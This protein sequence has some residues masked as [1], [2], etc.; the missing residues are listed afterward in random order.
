MFRTPLPNE[1]ISRLE[2]FGPDQ[3]AGLFRAGVE[4]GLRVVDYGRL[5]DAWGTLFSGLYLSAEELTDEMQRGEHR[6]SGKNERM[7]REFINADCSNGGLFVVNVI[8]KG[9]KTDRAALIMIADLENLA[10]IEYRGTTAVHLLADA[11][12]KGVRPVFI[13]KA[14]K[15]LLSHVYDRRGIPVI[16]TIFALGDLCM[17][18]LEAIAAVFSPEDLKNIMCRSRTGKNALTVFTEINLSLKSHAP[19]D[20]HTFFKTSATKDTDT[21]KKS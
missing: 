6:L 12:D 18:D 15:E 19:L 4:T 10:G 14:G 2:N 5:S 16:Y 21:G 3:L 17:A 9:G 7:L 13:R 8:M 1:D 11:C 20:R